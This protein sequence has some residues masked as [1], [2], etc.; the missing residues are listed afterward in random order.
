VKEAHDAA[1]VSVVRHMEDHYSLYRSPEGKLN[2]K[3]VVAKFDH[4]TSRNIDPQL[5]SHCF[6]LNDVLTPEG[7]C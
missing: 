3:I 7:H 2:G 4:A 6:I 5:H 1:V